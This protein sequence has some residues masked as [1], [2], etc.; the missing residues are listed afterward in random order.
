MGDFHAFD[1]VAVLLSGG[2]KRESGT[3]GSWHL[4]LA[5]LSGSGENF[6]TNNTTFTWECDL[7]IEKFCIMLL[8]NQAK[9]RNESK[10]LL[11]QQRW[12]SINRDYNR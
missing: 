7:R 5:L 8:L 11:T 10:Y 12:T 2:S 3:M 9:I 4:L 1:C 6:V